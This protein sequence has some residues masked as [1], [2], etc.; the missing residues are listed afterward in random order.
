LPKKGRLELLPFKN[1]LAFMYFVGREKEIKKILGAFKKGNNVILTGKFGI[2]RTT[3]MKHLARISTKNWRYVFIDFSQTPGKICRKLAAEL[4]P[5]GKP[6]KRTP[7]LGYK[8]NRFRLGHLDFSDPRQLILVMDNIGKL[9]NAKR[10]LLRYW[11]M[12]KRFLF[13]AISESFLDGEDIFRLRSQLSP[14]RVVKIAH[15]SREASRDFFRYFSDHHD[16][17]WT[18]NQI[19]HLAESTGGYPLGMREVANAK[20]GIEGPT[21][22]PD[23]L[24]GLQ[25]ST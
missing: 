2:G 8:S 13:A 14:A 16:L 24:R 22:K 23:H 11:A 5:K 7:N 6:N 17:L 3:L 15:L 19:D 4:L 18:E 21:K 12:P 20:I 25:G 1:G 9:T 10:D